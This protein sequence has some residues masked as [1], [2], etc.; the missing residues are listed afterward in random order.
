[1]Y[2]RYTQVKNQKK[3][4]NPIQRLI[5]TYLYVP[6]ECVV[7]DECKKKLFRLLLATL[8]VQQTTLREQYF[9][10]EERRRKNRKKKLWKI[11]KIKENWKSKSCAVSVFSLHRNPISFSSISFSFKM[12][13]GRFAE[14]KTEVGRHSTSRWWLTIGWERTARVEC[15]AHNN[16]IAHE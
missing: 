3:S 2:E 5:N 9:L 16:N 1:M 13:G 6:N 8:I 11:E 12:Q 4:R 14:V 15:C 10:S 7:D